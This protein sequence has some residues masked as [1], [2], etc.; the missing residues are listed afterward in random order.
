M[1]GAT[2]V[3]ARRAPRGGRVHPRV[4]PRGR[5][6]EHG[7]LLRRRVAAQSAL[8]RVP[9]GNYTIVLDQNEV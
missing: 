9:A 4:V 5:A 2:Y 7:G 8:R 1:A 3:Y 6:V